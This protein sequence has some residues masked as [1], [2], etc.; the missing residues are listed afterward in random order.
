MKL[1]KPIDTIFFPW[2]KI[3]GDELHPLFLYSCRSLNQINFSM[4]PGIFLSLG[5]SCEFI[6]DKDEI[7]LCR[8]EGENLCSQYFEV[9]WIE[10]SNNS[11]HK[12]IKSFLRDLKLLA[13][14]WIHLLHS[15]MSHSNNSRYFPGYLLSWYILADLS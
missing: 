2:F 11:Y 4:I 6:N 10:C 3:F 1:Y 14:I 13:S 7:S 12:F 15:C 9:K 8:E 5:Y